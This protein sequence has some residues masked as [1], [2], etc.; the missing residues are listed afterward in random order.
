MGK[1]ACGPWGGGRG[2][3]GEQGGGR[4][5]PRS[6]AL[7]YRSCPESREARGALTTGCTGCRQGPPGFPSLPLR[8][9]VARRHFVLGEPWDGDTE[10]PLRRRRRD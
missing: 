3:P 5:K 7:I 6:G 10:Q 1:A 8:D 4:R 9:G 2:V